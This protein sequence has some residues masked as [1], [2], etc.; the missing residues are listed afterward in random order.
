MNVLISEPCK[1]TLA[2][3]REVLMSAVGACVRNDNLNNLS[4]WAEV[5]SIT[6]TEFH[7]RGQEDLA[8]AIWSI[9]R[10]SDQ[11]IV[12]SDWTVVREMVVKV[13]ADKPEAS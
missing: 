5:L 6:A 4:P 7:A 10:R 11:S 3:R 8:E 1:E 2:L 9:L 13:D 12:G